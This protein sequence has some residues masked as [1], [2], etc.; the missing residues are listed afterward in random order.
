MST[1][2]RSLN[3][4]THAIRLTPTQQCALTMRQTPQK[5]G[6]RVIRRIP[7]N[8]ARLHHHDSS[9]NMIF[10]PHHVPL[11]QSYAGAL[12]FARKPCSLIRLGSKWGPMRSCT[13][14]NTWAWESQRFKGWVLELPVVKPRSGRTAEPIGARLRPPSSFA[15]GRTSGFH[16]I[17]V[18]R[19]GLRGV[20]SATFARYRDQLRWRV[21][22]SLAL[23]C[24][25]GQVC[26]STS[27]QNDST[28]RM[29]TRA[30]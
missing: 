11:R 20:T 7:G 5:R 14:G 22:R 6:E 24:T 17:S 2:L 1:R 8:I 16:L 28:G 27:P 10:V 29:W 30:A 4:S 26:A 19:L 13:L 23:I 15:R 9:L 12:V 18:D 3:P 25:M 21:A